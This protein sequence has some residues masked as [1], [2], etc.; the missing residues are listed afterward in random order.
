MATT[1][2]GLRLATPIT[3]LSLPLFTSYFSLL[4]YRVISVRVAT[5]T[6]VGN[7]C[8]DKGKAAS[9]QDTPDPLTIA[10]RCHANFAE[11]V[12]LALLTTAVAEL[13][14]A[15]PKIIAGGLGGL[16][17]LRV[18][19]VEL[20]LRRRAALGPGRIIGFLGTLVYLIG[21]GGYAGWLARGYLGFD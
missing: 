18:A 20:G 7:Q 16:F 8:V 1:T 10:S 17:L 2:L 12:P 9:T 11:Y 6:F 5:E 14:G 4:A 15:D 13:N 3:A 21:M 19:H